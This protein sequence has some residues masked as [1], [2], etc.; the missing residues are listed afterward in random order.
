VHQRREFNLAFPT[1]SKAATGG[2]AAVENFHHRM[3]AAACPRETRHIIPKMNANSSSVVP[4]RSYA[5][6]L[7][8]RRFGIRSGRMTAGNRSLHRHDYF[9]V[10]FFASSAASQRISIREHVSRRGSIFFISPMTAHQVRFS[11]G[12]SCYVIYFDHGFLRPELSAS[13]EIDI[14]LLSRAPELAPFVYQPDIDFEL[15]DAEVEHFMMLCDRML[16]ESVKPSLYANE[17]S[18]AYLIQLLAG[19]AQ[20]YESRIRVLM[21]ER[22]PGGGGERHV[23]GVMKFI[24]TNLAGKTSLAQ[25]ADAVSVSPN[26]LAG[27]LKRETGCTFVELVTRKRM[28]AAC[29]LLAF[30]SMRVMQVGYAAG[31]DDVDYFCRRFKQVVGCTPLEFRKRHSINTSEDGSAGASTSL[32]DA[33]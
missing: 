31:F 25:A 5:D 14:E 20:R 24:A 12:D 7:A 23:K 11:E 6:G 8:G 18:R 26:Y 10:L 19:V 15:S 32:E 33:A 2:S 30:T 22:P 16:A 3:S 27:L 28:D 21:R 4:V 13:N 9:E 1:T 17:I 29:E